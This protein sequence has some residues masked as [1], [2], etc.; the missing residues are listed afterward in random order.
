MMGPGTAYADVFEIGK[1]G[2]AVVRASDKGWSGQPIDA[3]SV[4]PDGDGMIGLDGLPMT[5][6][7]TVLSPVVPDAIRA[8]FLQAAAQADV[9]PVLLEALVWKE[10]R[11]RPD[12]LSVKGAMGLTQLMPD[13]AREL[14]VDP[15]DRAANLTGGARYL[16][17]M[18]DLF[19]GNIE[20][21]LAAYN[22]GPGRVRSA[23]GIPAI[24]ETRDY[25]SSIIDRLGLNSVLPPKG[26]PQ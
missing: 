3:T 10:S 4:M 24:A 5:A 22:A 6:L 9:S 7:T 25:V 19:D 1:N 26:D 13:T 20:K 23:R 21:A 16:R 15:R 18:L 12:A 2:A 11:W 8:S 17:K 14:L